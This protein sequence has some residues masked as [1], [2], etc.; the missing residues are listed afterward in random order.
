[1]YHLD[2]VTWRDTSVE[3]LKLWDAFED[4]DDKQRHRWES[5]SDAKIFEAIIALLGDAIEFHCGWVGH[6]GYGQD[7]FDRNRQ[8]EFAHLVL[9]DSWC[10]ENEFEHGKVHL[11]L[12][13]CE[14]IA[15]MLKN[16]LVE[17][18]TD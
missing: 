5:S 3:Y 18:Y 12:R 4:N 16:E 15:T 8:R 9:R 1:M 2:R 13:Y 11:A 10:I 14:R 7:D 6:W 17:L